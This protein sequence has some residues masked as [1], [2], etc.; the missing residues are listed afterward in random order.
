MDQDGLVLSVVALPLD[1]D[2]LAYFGLLEKR[3]PGL[4]GP[5]AISS[6]PVR[7]AECRRRKVPARHDGTQGSAEFRPPRAD[8]KRAD[9]PATNVPER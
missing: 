5:C 1:G 6:S 9:Q 3:Q 4:S 2:L 7:T 8:M